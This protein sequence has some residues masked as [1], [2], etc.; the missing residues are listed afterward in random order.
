MKPKILLTGFGTFRQHQANPTERIV[1]G[2]YKPD[3]KV[4]L[5]KKVLPVPFAELHDMYSDL[6]QDTQP[7]LIINLGLSGIAR[8]LE[9][10][11]VALNYCYDPERMET[12]TQ[13]ESAEEPAFFTRL[14]T[15]QLSRIL[16][17]AGIP[18]RQSFHAGIYT[19]NLVYFRSLQWCAWNG[20]DALFVHMPYTHLLAAEG[21]AAGSRAVGSSLSQKHIE[22]AIDLIVQHWM[23]ENNPQSAKELA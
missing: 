10:E 21:L 11:K 9:L 6:L 3:A 18:S 23:Q 14:D 8:T 20:G 22:R 15:Q 1:S 17:E 12:A 4:K 5:K 7:D 2:N 19:C 13:I 16:N